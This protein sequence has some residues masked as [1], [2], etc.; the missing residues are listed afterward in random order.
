MVLDTKI[1]KEFYPIQDN[2]KK[3]EFVSKNEEYIDELINY[4]LYEAIKSERTIMNEDDY[5]FLMKLVGI[6]DRHEFYKQFSIND[7]NR[8][9]LIQ[10][11]RR[12]REALCLLSKILFP[13][14]LIVYGIMK[15]K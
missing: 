9:L 7:C 2:A 5:R 8:L 1:Y 10:S 4:E 11:K 12:K 14:C 3:I 15:S 6:E 13:I